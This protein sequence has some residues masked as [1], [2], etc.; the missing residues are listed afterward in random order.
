M[1]NGESPSTV[2]GIPDRGEAAF[3]AVKGVDTA[4]AADRMMGDRELFYL[5]LRALRDEFEGTVA[6]VRREARNGERDQ[7]VSRLHRLAGL[8]GNLSAK[9][10][11]ALARDL[12][13]RF[14]TAACADED[15]LLVELE[16]ALAEVLADLP[17]DID[18]TPVSAL[19]GGDVPTNAGSI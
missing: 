12:E 7:A 6:A 19:A 4:E 18:D 16:H 8:A 17:A 3:P 14:C 11:A 13:A 2:D 10:I 1:M 15:S 5:A 9:R